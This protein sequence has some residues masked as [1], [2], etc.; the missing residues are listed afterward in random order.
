MI[1][2]E[3]GRYV[4]KLAYDA[5]KDFVN[6]DRANAF[7]IPDYR[8]HNTADSLQEHGYLIRTTRGWLISE[9]G[10]RK[11]ISTLPAKEQIAAWNAKVG[12]E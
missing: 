8:Y 12:G 11:Y 6:E 4:L 3:Y 7:I 9:K 2:G 1:V 5:H 10:I